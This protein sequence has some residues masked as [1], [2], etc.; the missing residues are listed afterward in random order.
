MLRIQTIGSPFRVSLPKQYVKPEVLALAQAFVRYENELPADEQTPFT[1]DIQTVLAEALTVQTESQMAENERKEFSEML[2]ET[3]AAAE[4]AVR[5]IQAL[6]GVYLAQAPVRAQAWGFTVRQTGHY[7][8]HI[9]LPRSRD[10]IILCL[11][12]YVE[13][14][15]SQPVEEQFSLPPLAEMMAL[16]DALQQQLV[17]RDEAEQ[18]RMQANVQLDALCTHLSRELRRALGYIMI[19][20]YE[21]ETDRMLGQ[22]GFRVVAAPGASTAVPE[23]EANGADEELPVP[24]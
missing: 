24:V 15:Q 16:R 14:E 7:A 22:W 4:T 17:A 20:R 1:A 18:R 19:M 8:G 13:K 2:K 9:L 5:Q 6:L 10:E 11:N 21:G 12:Q 23:P 3:E